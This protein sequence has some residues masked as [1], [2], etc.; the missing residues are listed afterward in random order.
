MGAINEA[1]KS[2]K[3]KEGLD[4]GNMEVGAR[5]L[6]GSW[7]GLDLWVSASDHQ[8]RCYQATTGAAGYYPTAP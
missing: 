5:A 4:A 7:P 3:R 2:Q 6:A 1:S 8:S